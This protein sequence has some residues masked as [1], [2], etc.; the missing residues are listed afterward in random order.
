MKSD[1]RFLKQNGCDQSGPQSSFLSYTEIF[2]CGC[3]AL[4]YLTMTAIPHVR[5]AFNRNNKY[6][7]MINIGYVTY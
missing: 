4:D 3:V 6:R 2:K 7:V 1:A 5:L